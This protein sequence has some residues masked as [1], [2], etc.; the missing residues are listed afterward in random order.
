MSTYSLVQEIKQAGQ[1]FEFYPTT[2]EIVNR[3]RQDLRGKYHKILDIGAGNG[4][5][6]KLLDESTRA[7]SE[8]EDWHS[9]YTKYA[10]EKSSILL[11]NLPADVF[12]VGTD[13][14]QQTLIDKQMDAIFCNPPY[15]EFAAWAVKII[16]QANAEVIYLVIPQRWKDNP[17]IK[18]A[19]KARKAFSFVL[20]SYDFM[21]AERSAR[22]KVDLVKIFLEKGY[23]KPEPFDI[24]FDEAFSF[25]ADKVQ[26]PWEEED[27]KKEELN[28]KL[29][30]GQ[31][32][33]ERL[34]ELYQDE[35]QRLLENYRAI[36]RLDA[37]ILKEL[38]VD[39]AGLKKG[40][41]LRLENTKALYWQQLFDRF[42][43]ITDR[44]TVKSRRSLF[45][46]LTKHTS[47]DYTSNN[48]Y[49]V[50]LW[51]IKNANKYLDEQLK[52]L[53]L[54]L[55]DPQNVIN[56]KSNQRTFSQERWRFKSEKFSHYKLDYRIVHKAWRCFDISWGE[57]RGL[58]QSAHEQ[59]NDVITIGKNLGF[60]VQQSSFNFN[61]EA[62]TP[63]VFTYLKDGEE[64]QF[65]RVKAFLNGNI[66]F[67]F[68]KEF[69]KAFNIE[70][71]RLF[72]W[73]RTAQEAAQELDLPI[74]EATDYFGRQH[75]SLLGVSNIKLLA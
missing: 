57:N 52:A 51:A 19:I 1:D 63:N 70:A 2:R 65:M 50:V 36:E 40:L 44:L 21:D 28:N 41:K 9:P 45:D 73:I 18:E 26:K 55:S 25:N 66:H 17:L 23:A 6:F 60:N 15:S 7:V 61:W 46:T 14:H 53:Y 59:I 5:F 43:P 13:F 68:C 20:G 39:V 35:M 74:K 54:E 32:L 10:I 34:E 67:Q 38:N 24:W 75:A 71:G 8:V 16:K 31:N 11:S 72:G 49:A 69:S 12:V 48:A 58:E 29:V 30:T 42:T 37:D 3:V 62:G 33:I 27:K 64:T 56:Y 4:N 47:I 22:A